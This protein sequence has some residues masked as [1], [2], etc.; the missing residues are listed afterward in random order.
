MHMILNLNVDF[1]MITQILRKT[2]FLIPDIDMR[3][4]FKQPGS[5]YGFAMICVCK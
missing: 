4:E 5:D 3:T 2:F 1:S